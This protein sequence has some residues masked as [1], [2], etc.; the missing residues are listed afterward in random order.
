VL[1]AEQEKKDA[2]AAQE[3]RRQKVVRYGYLGGALLLLAGGG[4]WFYTDRKRR[5]ETFQKEA[6]ELQTQALRS[7]MN[8]HFIFNALNSINAFVSGTIPMVSPPS[9]R[10]SR[11]SCAA[12]WRNSR[13]R[14]VM[15]KDD[16]ETLRGYIELERRRM[17]DKFDFTIEVDPAIDP[18]QV[19]VPPLVV[20]PLVENAIWHGIAGKQGRGHIALRCNSRTAPDLVH[21]GRRRRAWRGREPPRI[22]HTAGTAAKKTSLGTAITRS[23]LE[24]LQQQ[25]GGR[26]GFRY[27]DLPQG[28]RVVVDMPMV[29]A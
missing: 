3:I 29:M 18:E 20:Q 25:Y 22:L 21:R 8:P 7:Q 27:E 6:A 2:I 5:K 12:C 17:D 16:L 23:R 11:A 1:R 13:H 24:L 10:S 9:C 4:I 28:T 19:M 15:L 14:E 26:A